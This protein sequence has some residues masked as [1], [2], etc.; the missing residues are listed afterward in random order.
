ME[1]MET[2]LEKYIRQKEIIKQLRAEIKQLREENICLKDL[3]ATFQLMYDPP[4]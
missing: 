2:I 1:K 3:N 4:K